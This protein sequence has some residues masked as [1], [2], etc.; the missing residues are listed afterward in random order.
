[1]IELKDTLVEGSNYRMSLVKLTGAKIKDIVGYLVNEWGEPN[2]KLVSI[3][4]EDGTRL[5]V[6]GEHDM[7]Y[8]I[9]Y[10]MPDRDPANMDLETLR[11]LY[12]EA[13]ATS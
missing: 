5:D 2:F 9:A 11:R 12:Q 1:M 4:F 7:P 6:E 8:V 10:D 13:R 3:E